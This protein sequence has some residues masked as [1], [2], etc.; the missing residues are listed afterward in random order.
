MNKIIISMLTVVLVFL[1]CSCG[2]ARSEKLYTEDEFLDALEDKYDADFKIVDVE[3]I[4]K[5]EAYL[6]ALD[7]PKSNPFTIVGNF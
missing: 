1:A 4:N 2:A 3:N 5:K 6:F 7:T